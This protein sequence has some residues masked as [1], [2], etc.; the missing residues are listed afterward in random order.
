MPT[1]RTVV[2]AGLVLALGA[3]RGPPAAAASGRTRNPRYYF[4]IFE[5]NVGKYKDPGLEEAAREL[6]EKE[7]GSRPEF[8]SDLGDAVTDEAV[9]AALK[10]RALRGF[11][12]SLRLDDLGKQLVPPR[13]GGRL[14]QLAVTTKLSV[15]GTTLPGEKLAFGGEG[16]AV[17]EAEVV[18]SRLEAQT[19]ALVRDVLGQALKQAVDQAVM[20]LSLPAAAPLNESKR[21]RK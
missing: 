18:E 12:V 16:E 20:K 2:G 14:K 1:R 21:K 17:V 19:P 5:I 8:T 3:V 4:K 10:K 13:P 7:L 11:R 9:V 6:L 15:F